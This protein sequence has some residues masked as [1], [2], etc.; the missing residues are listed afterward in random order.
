MTIPNSSFDAN[1]GANPATT[2]VVESEDEISI[3]DLLQ[4]VVDNL[5]LLILGP[6][7]LG[8]IALG[9]SFLLTPVFTATTRFLPPQQQQGISSAMLQSLGA[10]GGLAAGASGLKNP[11][12]QYIG[13][14]RSQSVQDPIVEQFKLLDR[15]DQKYR[16]DARKILEGKTK[17]TSGKDGLIVIDYEDKD[18]VFAASLANS[19]VSKLGDLLSRLAIT[20]AQQRR[21]FFERQLTEAKDNLTKAEQALKS[22]GINSSVLRVT[23]QSAVEGIAKLQAQITAQ[24]IKM[25]GMRGY[26]TGSAPDL[27]QAQTE[28]NA[29]R[30]QLIRAQQDEPPSA[31]GG[32]GN[33]Y[34]ARYRDFKYNETLFELFARQYEL[35]RVDESR[36]GAVIQIVDAAQPP[37]KKSGPRRALIAI[38]ATFASFFILLVFVFGRSALARGSQDQVISSKILNLKFGFKRAFGR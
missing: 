28:L 15:F 21:L 6:L 36:E 9:I 34:I 37:E 26:L 14:L 1:S 8:V 25:S 32:G 33:D 35:A 2:P 29:L 7:A 22:T 4:V 16:E 19:Y 27:K 17:I 31:A 30:A 11:S 24:E 5:R 13:L 38:V 23:P 10:L 18:A 20:E 3:L 12:D